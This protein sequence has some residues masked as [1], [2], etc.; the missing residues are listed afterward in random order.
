MTSQDTCRAPCAV[1]NCLSL[2]SKSFDRLHLVI[3]NRNACVSPFEIATPQ[4]FISQVHPEV[5]LVRSIYLCQDALLDELLQEGLA[6][7][8]GAEAEK[9]GHALVLLL[10]QVVFV[11]QLVRGVRPIH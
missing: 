4:G 1:I 3:A 8:V 6:G 9:G 10:G 7:R 2:R 11:E 5:N